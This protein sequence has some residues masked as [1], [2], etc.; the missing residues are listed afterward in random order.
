MKF[1]EHLDFIELP[2]TPTWRFFS[3]RARLLTKHTKGD[4]ELS[5]DAYSLAPQEMLI[6][7]ELF[8]SPEKKVAD[9]AAWKSIEK[10]RKA[11]NWARKVERGGKR[12]KRFVEWLA[13]RK[14]KHDAHVQDHLNWIPFKWMTQR[15][16]PICRFGERE[17]RCWEAIAVQFDLVLWEEFWNWIEDLNR[18]AKLAGESA[19]L[20]A[21]CVLTVPIDWAPCRIVNRALRPMVDVQI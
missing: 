2:I 7:P 17:W 1:L 9:D 18:Q 10:F 4:L 19:E 16:C 14:D 12:M 13:L 21:Q 3:A 15:D 5:G 20:E 6:P 8:R 11:K